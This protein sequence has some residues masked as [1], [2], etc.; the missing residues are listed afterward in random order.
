M[1]KK[2]KLGAIAALLFFGLVSFSAVISSLMN[3]PSSTDSGPNTTLILNNRGNY[4][5]E[6][7][8]IQGSI[9]GDSRYTR[10]T[11]ENSQ[12]IYQGCKGEISPKVESEFGKPVYERQNFDVTMEGSIS[13]FDD[14]GYYFECSSVTFDQS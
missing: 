10:L 6:N 1:D 14:G 7:V 12:I 5:G 4:T 8:T 3:N 2:I 13:T 9:E 11:T